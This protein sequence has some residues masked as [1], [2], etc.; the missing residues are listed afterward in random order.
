MK[1]KNGKICFNNSLNIYN[2]LLIFKRLAISKLKN[3]HKT[4]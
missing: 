2:R 3:Q 4:S 1:S